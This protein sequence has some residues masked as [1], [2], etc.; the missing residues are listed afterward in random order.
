MWCHQVGEKKRMSV[1]FPGTVLHG[2]QKPVQL[3][4][5]VSSADGV[6]PIVATKNKSISGC[7]KSTIR[8]IQS[9]SQK[10]TKERKKRIYLWSIGFCGFWVCVVSKKIWN[11]AQRSFLHSPRR[12]SETHSKWGP[13][14]AT[15]IRVTEPRKVDFISLLGTS[16][17]TLENRRCTN[18]IEA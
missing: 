13:Y 14:A 11:P 2:N 17:L 10:K 4:Q 1:G 16:A 7:L 8:V 15:L 5:L 3:Y 12:R 9:L 18:L 6:T